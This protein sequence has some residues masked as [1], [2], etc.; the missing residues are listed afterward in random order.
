VLLLLLLLQYGPHFAGDGQ[1]DFDVFGESFRTKERA[2]VGREYVLV[3]FLGCF[4]DGSQRSGRELG[5]LFDIVAAEG[6]GAD[7]FVRFTHKDVVED[8]VVAATRGEEVRFLL[9]SRKGRRRARIFQ[10][11]RFCV[12]ENDF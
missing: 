2:S 3:P 11:T 5:E 8:V 1:D 12:Q 6:R 4:I 7:V 9:L 10:S